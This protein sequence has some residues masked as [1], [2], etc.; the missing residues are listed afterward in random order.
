MDIHVPFRGYFCLTF[1]RKEVSK[2][3]LFFG[4]KYTHSVVFV[5]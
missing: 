1:T 5:L 3:E 2:D 4:T